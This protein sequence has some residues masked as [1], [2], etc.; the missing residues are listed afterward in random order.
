MTALAKA[1]FWISPADYL[2]GEIEAKE[3][4][5]YLGGEV[6]AMAETT[7]TH[8]L[9][10]G[11]AYGALQRQLRGKPCQ[12]YMADVK[13]KVDIARD[14]YFYYPDVMVGCDPSDRNP[15]YLTRPS[16]I[17]EVLS[18]GTE[19]IDRREKF[20]IFQRLDSL[21]LYI[22][23]DPVNREVTVHSKADE[24]G[25]TIHSGEATIALDC[26]GCTLSTAE[27]FEGVDKMLSDAVS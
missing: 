26:I 10:A 2:S 5:E 3:R 16:V 22:L 11:N 15:L 12:A 13:V 27:I 25:A 14:T 23:I 9:I 7:R 17:M 4:H 1:D 24:W 18:P 6:Y 20:F 21:Q 8:N 19:R